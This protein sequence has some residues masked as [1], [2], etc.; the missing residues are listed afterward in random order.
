MFSAAA[1]TRSSPENSAGV[2]ANRSVRKKARDFISFH[3]WKDDAALSPNLLP[4]A[5]QRANR[6][7]RLDLDLL[8]LQLRLAALHLVGE[9]AHFVEQRVE[10]L[11]FADR[12][13]LL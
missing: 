1:P 12:R 8:I 5:A 10:H 11:V 4:P 6:V 3:D 13:D 9:L 7:R 2:A